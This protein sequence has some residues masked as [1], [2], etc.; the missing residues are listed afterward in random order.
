MTGVQTCALPIYQT[1]E[2]NKKERVKI[3]SKIIENN[4][5]KIVFQNNGVLGEEKGTVYTT[6]T[7]PGYEESLISGTSYAEESISM[8]VGVIEEDE[9]TVG[10]LTILNTQKGDAI[11]VY[12]S[13]EK[14]SVL[15]QV[16]SD[17]NSTEIYVP[18]VKVGDTIFITN[19]AID[20]EE[21]GVLAYTIGNIT[22][23]G[24]ISTDKNFVST[25]YGLK[26][27]FSTCSQILIGLVRVSGRSAIRFDIFDENGKKVNEKLI[28]WRDGNDR[29]NYK[30]WITIDNPQED[31]KVHLY[32]IRVHQVKYDNDT[33]YRL[34]TGNA[35]NSR[36]LLSGM[37][38]S[39]AVEPYKDF[40]SESTKKGGN[41][42][43][44]EY[45]PGE[46]GKGYFYNFKY[47]GETIT[48]C[49]RKADLRFCIYDENGEIRYDSNYDGHARRIEWMGGFSCVQ[50][51]KDSLEQ[52]LEMGE[53]YFVEVYSVGS[54]VDFEEDYYSYHLAIGDPILDP[55]FDTFYAGRTLSIPENGFSNVLAFNLQGGRV[56]DT[57][58]VKRISPKDNSGRRPH[59]LVAITKFR[60][61]N[62]TESYSVWHTCTGFYT[63]CEF[64][65]IANSP[66]STHLRGRWEIEAYS[67]DAITITPGFEVEY[68]YE[69]GD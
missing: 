58:L 33:S 61:R 66:V 59:E 13:E 49:T 6:L 19:K 8:R 24:E 17:G 23:L 46:M 26:A 7:Y 30:R 62:S 48:L 47:W 57:A 27:D 20:R 52:S 68:Y 15:A 36:E 29:V 42:I 14:N 64:T 1:T 45:I 5:A 44:G 39:V 56:P 10:K 37:E 41:L 12:D 22:E 3:A 43:L 54:I 25:T 4:R 9:N 21:S 53:N 2:D 32:N 35:Q 31:S 38:N 34:V 11:R 60:V 69:I 28:G 67:R 18:S 51:A 55:H 40:Y 50:K 65:M 16:V 63:S